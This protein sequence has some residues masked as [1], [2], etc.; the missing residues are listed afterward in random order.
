MNERLGYIELAKGK[1][2]F[3]EGER[4][5]NLFYLEKGEIGLFKVNEYGKQTLLHIYDEKSF[6]GQRAIFLEGPL[7]LSAE[8]LTDCKLYK[9]DPLTNDKD[10]L[11]KVS[12]HLAKD[13]R[14]VEE[15]IIGH[16]QDNALKKIIK[17]VIY[18][19]KNY[20]GKYCTRENI[21]SHSGCD[22]ATVIRKL[23][24]LHKKGLIKK[25]KKKIIIPCFQQL[26]DEL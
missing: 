17:S 11:L 23:S 9:L 6:L 14:A 1:C 13:L 26:K 20:Q 10:L 22:P 18:L 2:L 15:R 24:F 25:E 8:A 3:L 21:S 4:V 5:E 19:S 7:H 12:T 16:K